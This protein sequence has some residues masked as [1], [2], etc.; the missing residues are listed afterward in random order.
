[1]HQ[2]PITPNQPLQSITVNTDSPTGSKISP[3]TTKTVHPMNSR[4]QALLSKILARHFYL[5]IFGPTADFTRGRLPRKIR[6]P[7]P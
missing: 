5:D 7:D 6:S 2:T 4:I 3:F 1:M